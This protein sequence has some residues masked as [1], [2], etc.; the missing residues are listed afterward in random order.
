MHPLDMIYRIHHE[1]YI[2]CGDTIRFMQHIPNAYIDLIVT[3]PPYGMDYKSRSKRMADKT[4]HNYSWNETLR[5]LL[6]AYYKECARILKPEGAIY[7]FCSHHHVDFFKC[8]IEANLDY[9]D[10]LIWRKNNH[11]LTDFSSHYAPIYEMII[12]AVKGKHKLRGGFERNVLDFAK[13]SAKEAKRL[14]HPTPKPVELLAHL[15]AKSSEREDI[16]FDGFAG[17][18]R[19]AIAALEM[20]RRFLC[21]EIKPKHWRTAVNELDEID[22]EWRCVDR[23]DVEK[24]LFLG[25]IWSTDWTLIPLSETDPKTLPFYVRRALGVF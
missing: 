5:M 6:R 2:H 12:Y 1:N 9:R 11:T 24:D 10:I 18:G 16:V 3:D 21:A 19:T 14:Q 22:P 17:S 13:V 4:V 7:S 25:E 20:D 15:I 8:E 23:L